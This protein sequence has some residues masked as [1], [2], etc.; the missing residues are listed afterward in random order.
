MRDS[1]KRT[2]LAILDAITRFPTTILVSR[3]KYMFGSGTSEKVFDESQDSNEFLFKE[4]PVRS[5]RTNS[6]AAGLDGYSYEICD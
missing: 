6:L 5:E 3:I 1:A 2:E 4:T